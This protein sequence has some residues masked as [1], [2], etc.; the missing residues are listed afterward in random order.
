M[1]SF[2]TLYFVKGVMFCK[3]IF[4]RINQ[5]GMSVYIFV[6]ILSVCRRNTRMWI[7]EVA[8]RRRQARYRLIFTAR[9][10]QP[11]AALMA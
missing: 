10:R 11:P 9:Y 7:P 8:A 4:L 1:L 3:R 5:N 6:L 2:L